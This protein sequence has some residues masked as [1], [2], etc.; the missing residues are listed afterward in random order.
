MTQLFQYNFL[1][2]HLFFRFTLIF[3][4]VR[5]CSSR[6]IAGIFASNLSISTV[7]FNFEPDSTKRMG[8]DVVKYHNTVHGRYVASKRNVRAY[9]NTKPVYCSTYYNYN[10]TDARSRPAKR[11]FCVL[12]RINVHGFLRYTPGALSRFNIFNENAYTRTLIV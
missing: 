8:Y 1:V 3:T 5:E 12:S 4:G 7:V 10:T 2:S 9:Y 6:C 11:L